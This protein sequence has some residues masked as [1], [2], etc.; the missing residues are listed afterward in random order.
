MLKSVKEWKKMKVAQFLLIQYINAL[1]VMSD[2]NKKRS[3]LV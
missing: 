3:D 2:F 1:F